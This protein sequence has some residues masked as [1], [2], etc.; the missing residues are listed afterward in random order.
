VL[1]GQVNSH[2]LESF[3]DPEV[4]KKGINTIREQMKEVQKEA[5][6]IESDMET[7]FKQMLLQNEAKR[8][9]MPASLTSE[10][11]NEDEDGRP[12][13]NKTRDLI[14]ER[15]GGPFD[16]FQ[17]SEDIRKVKVQR[18]Q[19]KREFQ[20]NALKK[21]DLSSEDFGGKKAYYDFSTRPLVE[22]TGGQPS[23]TENVSFDKPDYL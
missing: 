22:P 20:M 2:Q 21:P 1:N 15:L 13:F 14:I 11:V 19:L 16:Y 9:H 18:E 5:H 10:M 4:V 23:S 3:L 8:R 6:I 12:T 17:F 7:R